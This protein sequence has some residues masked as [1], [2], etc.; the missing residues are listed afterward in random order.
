[1]RRIVWSTVIFVLL[2]ACSGHGGVTPSGVSS[3]PQATKALDTQTGS[4]GTASLV[5]NGLGSAYAQTVTY[6]EQFEGD[7]TASSANPTVASVDPPSVRAAHDPGTGSKT[8]TFIITPVGAG[9]TKITITDKQGGTAVITVVVNATKDVLVANNPL[10]SLSRYSTAAGGTAV[11]LAT[12]QAGQTP[13]DLTFDSAGNLYVVTP[14]QIRVYQNGGLVR[15]LQG[16][17]ANLNCT[18]SATADQQGDL[19]VG[20]CNGIEVF[21]AGA[22]GNISP[23]RTMTTSPWCGSRGVKLDGSGNVYDVQDTWCSGNQQINVFSASSSGAV[24]PA[25]IV[26]SPSLTFGTFGLA[27]DSSGNIFVPQNLGYSSSILEFQNGNGVESPLNVIHGGATQLCGIFDVAEDASND[28]WAANDCAGVNDQGITEYA[29]GSSGDVTPIAHITNGAVIGR[30]GTIAIDPNG[31]PFIGDF[32]KMQVL[33]FSSTAGSNA[34]PLSTISLG[35]PGLDNPSGLEW[36]A[37]GTL[38]G[39][40]SGLIW[41]YGSFAAGSPAPAR[42][43]GFYPNYPNATDAIADASG[44]VYAASNDAG[45]SI[46]VYAPGASGAAAPVR[47]ISGPGTG[48]SNPR[49]ICFDARGNLVVANSGNNSVTVFSATSSGNASPTAVISGSSTQLANPQSVAVSPSGEIYVAN[50]GGPGGSTIA[51][52]APGAAGNATPIRVL[53]AS[54]SVSQFAWVQVDANGYVYTSDGWNHIYVWAPG[55]TGNALPMR[56]ILRNPNDGG[57]WRGPFLIA[58]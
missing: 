43:I 4:G 39:A 12:L 7:V 38:E 30:P 45:G 14:G 2:T 49:A 40:G 19:Y 8:A 18:R 5:F 33:G 10:N 35:T 11:A 24:V 25:R 1:M 26:S 22:S 20:S 56:T 36:G 50:A 48:L 27:L 51:A 9:A 32:E 55:S 34:T 37:D 46:K 29:P 6:S 31:N 42:T 57:Q 16:D 54:G 47:T 13:N 23:A 44:T 52:F 41:V 15:S 28:V 17:N 53:N 58:K 21:P 3:V